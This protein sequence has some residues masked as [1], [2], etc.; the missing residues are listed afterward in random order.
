MTSRH[1][2]SMVPSTDS[3]RFLVFSSLFK[4]ALKPPYSI[5]TEN[6][7]SAIWDSSR[8][9]FFVT[10][11]LKTAWDISCDI[12]WP[13]L[14]DVK[15]WQYWHQYLWT[16]LCQFFVNLLH[17]PPVW[18]FDIWHLFDNFTFFWH[19][20]P[21]IKLKPPQPVTWLFFNKGTREII[22]V[23]YSKVGFEVEGHR[24]NGRLSIF[25]SICAGDWSSV[26][27]TWDPDG[28]RGAIISNQTVGPVADGGRKCPTVSL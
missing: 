13:L 15:F 18:L 6:F 24:S 21:W 4:F 12:L 23:R 1:F 14:K 5:T 2:M 22:R 20:D 17:S 3:Q 25:L 10:F 19:F 7:L 28:L 26:G 16:S 9:N 8:W 27:T 11:G